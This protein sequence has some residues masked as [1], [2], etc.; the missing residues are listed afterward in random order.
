MAADGGFGPAA[1]EQEYEAGGDGI[2]DTDILK[3]IEGGIASAASAV[4]GLAT[5][6]AGK[7]KNFIKDKFKGFSL[8][9][10]LP[11]KGKAKA[12]A[13]AGQANTLV[14]DI[15][16]A[17]G[18]SNWQKVSRMMREKRPLLLGEK[19]GNSLL[20]VKRPSL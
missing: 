10:Y 9:D 20:T 1:A 14:N 3:G 5:S 11:G 18:L 17:N 7:A 15:T 19:N 12:R 4:R 13:V 6:A 16:P 8:K 2:Y